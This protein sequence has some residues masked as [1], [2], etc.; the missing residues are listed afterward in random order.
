MTSLEVSPGPVY[1]SVIH[2]HTHTHTHTE[3][4]KLWAEKCW[5]KL[6]NTLEW[7][8]DRVYYSWRW[9]ADDFQVSLLQQEPVATLMNTDT[10]RKQ[11]ATAHRDSF[12]VNT[13]MF[14]LQ[15][16]IHTKTQCACPRGSTKHII[17][18]VK[19]WFEKNIWIVNCFDSCL[20]PFSFM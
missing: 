8:R 20:L 2:T 1:T 9:W 13:L 16:G 10:P 18:H 7:R 19:S 6:D 3:R 17:I 4:M 5:L 15:S 14:C 12:P 11:A